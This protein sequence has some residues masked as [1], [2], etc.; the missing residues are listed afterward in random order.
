[1]LRR[2][3]VSDEELEALKEHSLYELYHSDEPQYT[4]LQCI[5]AL[6]RMDYVSE[7]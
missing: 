4:R 3:G 7:P 5:S 6:K 1:M 2:A